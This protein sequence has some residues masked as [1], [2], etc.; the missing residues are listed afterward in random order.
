M[1]NYYY[2]QSYAGTG[3]FLNLDTSKAI[4]SR[5]NVNIWEKSCPIDQIWEIATLG[6]NQQVKTINNNSFMLNAKTGT[7]DCD[8][9]TSNSDTYVNFVKVS[10]DVYYIQLVSNTSRYLTAA[11]SASGSEVTWKV[12][13]STDSGKKAQQWK[14]T[15]TTLPLNYARVAQGDNTLGPAQ[16]KVNA[17]YI[18]YYLNSKYGYTKEAVCG[19]LGNMQYEST[20]NPASWR[21]L[22]IPRNAFG[23]V[24]WNPATKFLYWARENGKIGSTTADDEK[25][26][27]A[28][29]SLAYSDPKM[30]MTIELEYLLYSFTP[31][32]WFDSGD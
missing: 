24:H 21:E 15:K 26:V 22:N 32:N 13:S 4:T 11:G 31:A 7:W 29:D 2:I 3:E 8:V 9:Y 1:A 12:M 10:T 5:T 25:L 17:G 18:Y 23:V 30:L 19:I 6:T 20:I 28:V 27:K 16:M 14:V